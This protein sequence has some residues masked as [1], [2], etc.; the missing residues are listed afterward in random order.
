MAS[1]YTVF[2]R[3]EKNTDSGFWRNPGG[4]VVNVKE[5]SSR[6]IWRSQLM[7]KRKCG[8]G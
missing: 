4:S 1:L 3:K 7:Q 8:C 6:I 5:D 2:E